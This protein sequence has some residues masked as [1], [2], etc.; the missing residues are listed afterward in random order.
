MIRILLTGFILTWICI[1]NLSGQDTN[2]GGKAINS[3]SIST[4]DPQR[5]D[6]LKI[7]LDCDRCD[8]TFIKESIPY[9]NYINNRDD[10]D[11]FIIMTRRSTGG[12]G[13]EHLISF[14]GQKNYTGINDTLVFFDP[15]NSTNDFTRQGQTNTLS[16]GLMRYVARTPLSQNI[17]I[18]YREVTG[19]GRQLSQVVENDPWNSWVFRFSS[20]GSI[21]KDQNYGTIS[22]NNSLSADRVTPEFKSEFDMRFDFRERSITTEGVTSKYTTQNDFRFTTLQVKSISP[23]FSVGANMSAA[24]SQFGNIKYELNFNPAIEYNIFPY[25]ESFMRQVR[26][27]YTVQIGYNNYIDTTRYFKLEE[28][29]Y[30]HQL[31]VAIGFNQQ[32]GSSNFSFRGGHFLNDASFWSFNMNGDVEWRVYRGLSLSF[33]ARAAI[34]RDD[35]AVLKGDASVEEVL[36][37]LRKLSSTYSFQAGFGISYSFGSIYNNVVNPRFSSR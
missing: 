19:R 20:R 14:S 3:D 32:W 21:N 35:R 5:S 23:H 33:N 13:T 28:M 31:A 17:R 24:S 7:F 4:N 37:Q 11:V 36:L 15:P 8:R 27:Q 9:V 2:N 25:S 30:R 12:G 18:N 22:S 1:I 26:V 10:A 16:M 29:I 34:I 6:A